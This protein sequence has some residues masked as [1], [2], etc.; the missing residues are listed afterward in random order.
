MS[1][2]FA[3]LCLSTYAFSHE[4][5][6]RADLVGEL[7]TRSG[8]LHYEVLGEG[9][10]LIM[11]AG[12]PGAAHVGLR[13]FFD[14]LA[15]RFKVIYIDN[16]GR[17]LSSDLNPGETHSPQRDA[18]DIEAVRLALN[19]KRVIL[20]GHSYGA[21]V[22]LDYVSRFSSHVEKLV[23]SSGGYG[24]KSWQENIDHH[25]SFVQK[26]YP[27]VWRKLVQLRAEGVSS[28]DSAYL[29]VYAA[30]A[31]DLLWFNPDNAKLLKPWWTDPR[32][33]FKLNVYCEIIGRDSEIK[34]GGTMKD[35]NTL[36]R[37]S[38]LNMPVWLAVGR[39]DRIAMPKV[40]LDLFESLP[41]GIGT[42]RVFEKSGHFPW[43]EERELYFAQLEQFLGH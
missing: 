4:I 12:G 8:A 25:N 42:L 5:P 38:H 32:N 7:K 33:A 14:R 20:V 36:G 11:I 23:L 27:E 13:P 1:L 28:C 43:V 39:F 21:Y 6:P 40:A 26:Q 15:K 34:V 18:D 2:W 35:F 41:K 16:I 30:A 29:A 22:A 17:G 31:H 19:L 9:F 24:E 3:A 10:P 37:L